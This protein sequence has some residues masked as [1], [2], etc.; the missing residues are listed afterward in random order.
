[1]ISVMFQLWYFGMRLISAA[2]QFYYITTN[3]NAEIKKKKN[4]PA[5]QGNSSAHESLIANQL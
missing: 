2:C 4:T 5:N 3:K 1:M